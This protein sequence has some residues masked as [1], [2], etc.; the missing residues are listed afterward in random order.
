M[1]F[2]VTDAVRETVPMLIALYGPTGSGKTFSG[3]LL[4]GGLAGPDGV[5]GMLDAENKRGSLYADDP[6]IRRAM[7]KGRY[8]RVDMTPPYTPA[9]YIEALKALEKAGCTVALVDST[10][11]EWSGE[12]GCCDIAENNKLGG[13][14]NWAKAKMEHKKFMAYC[15]SSQ[16]HIVFCLRAHEKV[17]PVKAGDLITPDGTDRYEK[18][19]VI[20]MGMLPDTEKNF[21]FEMLL[22]LRVDD[23]TH[24]AQPVKVPKMLTHLFPGGRMVTKADGEAVRIWNEGGAAMD[25]T[26]QLRKRA[27]AEAEQGSKAYEAFW[28]SLTKEQR[29]TLKDS[30]TGN[31]AAALAADT[32]NDKL[33]DPVEQVL[34]ARLTCKSVSYVVVDSEDGYKWAEAK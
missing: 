8:K 31:K 34:G 33:P 10:T 1:G 18:T 16:M 14:P 30:H 25:L 20:P 3:L 6:D 11:H 26:E 7:P 12:G 5:V 24:F 19:A 4:A 23:R 32:G 9:R 29:V 27:R 21:V 13:F 2:I 28:G 17:K 22:S 15:L